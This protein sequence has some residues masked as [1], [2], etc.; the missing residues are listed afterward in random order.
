MAESLLGGILGE[1]EEKA[2]VEAP[3]VLAGAEAFAAAVAARLSASDPEVARN[4]S[5]FLKKQAQI[6]ET[7]N[8]HLKEEHAARLHFLQGQAREVDIR[9]FGLRLR[10]GFQLFIALLATAIAVALIL[11]VH[12]AV[13]SRSVIVDPFETPAALEGT[14]TT[15]KVVAAGVLDEL[16][17]LQAA[18]RSSS[19]KRDLSSAWSHEVTLS[20]PETGVSLGE[21]SRALKSR[22]G[23]D[24]HIEGALM[25]PSGGLRLTVRGNG[26][27]A[28]AFTAGSEE[29]T[30]SPGQG[31]GV[32]VFAAAAILWATYSTRWANDEAIAF[33]RAYPEASRPTVHLLSTGVHKV[34]SSPE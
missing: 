32:C 15:G 25:R 4:T 22:F 5:A 26:V 31:C 18:T 11:M 23:H 21:I 3:S 17:R 7:Q 9:R 13:T 12:D 19:A 10:V 14:G 29:L 8:E 28:M 24:L 6:L 33:S 2:E 34:T 16:N 27:P 30:N 20:V 1:E